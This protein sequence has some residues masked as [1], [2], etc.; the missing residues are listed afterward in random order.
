V[1]STLLLGACTEGGVSKYTAPPQVVIETPVDGTTL[2]EGVAIPMRGRVADDVYDSSLSSI[3]ATWAVDGARVC[4]AAVF[5]DDGTSDCD[6]SFTAGTATVSLTA[7][8]PDGESASATVEL[9]IAVN[10]AP[11]AEIVEPADGQPCYGNSITSFEALVGDAEDLEEDLSVAWV[12]S[13][14]GALALPSAPTSDGKATGYAY[15]TVGEHQLTLTVTDTTGRTGQDTVT[16]DVIAG[17]PPEVE[18]VTPRS[19]DVV[20]E[21]DTVYFEATVDD[22]EDAEQDLS[23]AWESSIDGVF[24]TQGASS[25]GTADFVYGELSAGTH[26]ITVTVTDTDGIVGT[27]NAT[28]IVNA[29]PSAPVVEISPD[30]AGSDD[31]LTVNFTSPAVDAD[32]DPVTYTYAWYQNS[33]LTAYVSNPLP[34]A[35]TSRGEVWT[36]E[37]TPNDGYGDGLFGSDSITIGNGTPSLSSVT[38]S[39][40][41]AYTDDTLSAVASGYSDPDGDAENERYQWYLGGVAIAGA[42]DSTLSG[43]YFVKG[44]SITV[45]AWPYDGT[46]LGASVTSGARD[47]QNSV[48][49]QP[50]VAISPEKPETDDELDCNVITAS[51]DADGDSIS[52]G[53]SWTNNGSAT[54]I[55]SDTVD[56]SYTADGEVW[57]CTVTP[58]DGTATGTAG[59]DSVTV[60]DYT[61]P[62]AP[63]L[64]SI[65]PYRNEDTVVITGTTDAFLDVTLYMVDSTGTA[66]DA[67]SASGA[68]SFTFSESLTR[69]SAY[70]FYATAVDSAGNVSDPSNT[71]STE[72]CDPWDEYEDSSGYGDTCTNGIV[73][74][75]T[76]TDDGATT[77]TVQGNLLDASDEDWY[78]VQTTD[79]TTSGINYYRFHVELTHGS[80][81]YAFA[82]YDGGCTDAYLDC[83]S[84]SSSDPEG[85]GYTEYEYYAE[86]VGDG[87]HTVPS[88]TRTCAS[89]GDYN[90]CD[91]LSSDYYIHIIRTD[92]T[93][94]CEYYELTIT[95]GV[96]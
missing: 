47:I 36:V 56:P 21:G 6:Y 78:L 96:W 82:V 23:F 19:G 37:V 72:V 11:T 20:N 27:D 14:D 58:T 49:T 22:A 94:S 85:D 16:V 63:V 50:V 76:L 74:W 70:T 95:N 42:T 65:D 45:E 17:S 26:T 91:D 7:T 57:E 89:G 90:D 34:A 53:Y 41:P 54:G 68:G 28:L 30:P 55:V 93:Y 52:Y 9:T 39:P 38:I 77:L 35:A 4:E 59:T 24:S 51:T 29:L 75:S 48:P 1:I 3:E 33:V 10:N 2:D 25:S 80:G 12:S 40:D 31:D 46:E 81:S 73:D 69:G 66:T 32:G 67:T 86:D 71:L 43:T 61:A 87:S 83:G 62:D 92:G 8:N 5:G 60:N 13:L 15:L 64:D 18:L 44:D 79:G 84:G 88:D